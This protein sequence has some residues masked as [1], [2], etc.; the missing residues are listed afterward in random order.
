MAF[1][2]RC[3]K[4]CL[5]SSRKLHGRGRPYVRAHK[6]WRHY[7]EVWGLRR[8]K[9]KVRGMLGANALNYHCIIISL[10]FSNRPKKLAFYFLIK[11]FKQ[12]EKN[13]K[14]TLGNLIAQTQYISEHF[15]YLLQNCNKK[16][17]NRTHT[18]ETHV[19][20]NSKLMSFPLSRL[21]P[22]LVS[23]YLQVCICIFLWHLY[24]FR[25]KMCRTS[26]S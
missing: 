15:L 2:K 10:Q 23:V 19:S 17:Q 25:N 13:I 11:N 6:I 26:S 18:V 9:P 8:A 1:V 21:V 14:K 5:W 7:G 3:D 12:G 22:C 4:C 20:P 16:N 24:I